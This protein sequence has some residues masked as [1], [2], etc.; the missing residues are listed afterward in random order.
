MGQL[1][2]CTAWATENVRAVSVPVIG[3][4]MGTI[5]DSAD[6]SFMEC[7]SGYHQS[8]VELG[9]KQCPHPFHGAYHVLSEL[10][11]FSR[12]VI[13]FGSVLQTDRCS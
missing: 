7:I 5:R 1:V 8:V 3:G 10:R 2:V 11:D 4:R 6:R 13:A 9:D 12:S